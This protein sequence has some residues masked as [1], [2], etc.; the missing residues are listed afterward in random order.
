MP[1]PAL[2][3][4]EFGSDSTAFDVT[5][6]L[7]ARPTE[8]ILWDAQYHVSDARKMVDRIAATGKKL[9]AIVISHPDHDH[10][11]GAAV[12]V[13]RFPGTPVY[14][15]AAALEEYQKT[16][17]QALGNERPLANGPSALNP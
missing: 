7:V 11:M 3:I 17:A 12:V 4:E 15:T 6:T 8:A 10:Y 2:T 14:L 16:S 9:K 5:A 1:A 13:A